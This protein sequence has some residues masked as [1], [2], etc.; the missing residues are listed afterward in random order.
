[1]RRPTLGEFILRIAWDVRFFFLS[2]VNGQ[3]RF[4]SIRALDICSFVHRFGAYIFAGD[5]KKIPR[6]S[7]DQI[8]RAWRTMGRRRGAI[9]ARFG[10]QSIIALAAALIIFRPDNFGFAFL[11]KSLVGRWI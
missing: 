8:K 5:Q 3:R 2:A 4:T 11:A 6:K 10:N 9:S 1:M 7:H